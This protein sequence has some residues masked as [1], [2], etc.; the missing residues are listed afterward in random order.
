MPATDQNQVF[1]KL[2]H[3]IICS[4]MVCGVFVPVSLFT[5]LDSSVSCT[6]MSLR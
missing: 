2:S 3:V 4:N 5:W 1:W 6:Y